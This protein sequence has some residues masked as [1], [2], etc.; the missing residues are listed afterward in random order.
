MS[1]ASPLRIVHLGLGAFHRAHQA[2]YLQRLIDAGER[3]WTIVAGNLRPDQE[4]TVEAL[5]AQ[6]G[7]Y[8]LETVAPSGERSYLRI[9][10][11]SEVIG[12]QPGLAPLI[13]AG[14]APQTR[15]V[16][17]TV[18]EAGYS[19][20]AGGQLDVGAP[21]VVADLAALADGTT[22]RTIYGALVLLLRA[23][24]RRGA[25]PL[26]L[27][28]CDNLRHN[29]ERV[30]AALLRFV[31][32][33]GDAALR[34]WIEAATTSPS[35]MVDRITPRPTA[36]VRARVRAATGVDDPAALM[37]ERFSQWVIE[38]RFASERPR[39]ED[40]GVD[41]VASVAPYEEAKIRLLNATHSAVAWGGTL[42]GTRYI[43]EGVGDAEIRAFAERYL[44]VDA[45]PALGASPL[46]LHAYGASVLE[47]FGN[48]FIRDTNERVAVD[49]F[50][51]LAGFVMPTVRDRLA[52]GQPIDAVAVLPALYL[53]WL[54]RWRRGALPYAYQDQALAPD[55]A[56]ALCD[57][58]DPVAQLARETRLWGA[59]AGDER[60][61]AALRGAA[62]QVGRF[63]ASRVGGAPPA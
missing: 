20:D 9:T 15:I 48:P 4:A 13:E 28:C 12:W 27:L 39:W 36:E 53:A 42:A 37:C 35:S 1:T 5:R 61:L 38:D 44:T 25:G 50:A 45:I 8:T 59:C 55:A 57:S 22:C 51:K 47:R 14:A 60:L 52:Q 16:S 63:E 3:R 56:A 49:G 40:V 41:I 62:T 24:M 7:A 58:G 10:A 29:G 18:T 17:F 43:H 6:G 34:A 54:Q 31:D 23:R 33:L 26:T 2:A 46:D 21:D 30:R 32:A 11:I 19:F